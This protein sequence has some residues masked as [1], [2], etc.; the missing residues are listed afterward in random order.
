MWI[1]PTWAARELSRNIYHYTSCNIME[2]FIKA[3]SVLYASLPSHGAFME[4]EQW[5][6]P[7]G[8]AAESFKRDLEMLHELASGSHVPYYVYALLGAWPSV[9]A[10]DMDAKR[11]QRL[12]AVATCPA[13]Q[14]G[15]ATRGRCD[16][17]ADR[18]APAVATWRAI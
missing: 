15:A 17:S 18:K 9:V 14:L 4:D 8:Q 16:S 6:Q 12:L 1:R 3:E 5:L 11:L 7:P 10:L 13:D 2:A